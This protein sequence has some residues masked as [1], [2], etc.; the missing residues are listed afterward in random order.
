MSSIIEE[1][2]DDPLAFGEAALDTLA[3]A[4]VALLAQGVRRSDRPDALVPGADGAEG[5]VL[6]LEARLPAD[7]HALFTRVLAAFTDPPRRG[8]RRTLGQRRADAVAAMSRRAL[9]AEARGGRRAA[10]D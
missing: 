8:D 7:E 9:D 10:F 5:G 3:V 4:G 6:D 2:S 1:A